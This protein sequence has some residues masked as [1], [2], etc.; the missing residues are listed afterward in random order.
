MG[1][2]LLDDETTH[3]IPNQYSSP[4]LSLQHSDWLLDLAYK[5]KTHT[6]SFFQVPQVLQKIFGKCW[7]SPC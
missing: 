3:G 2:Y 6:V 4:S 7:N 1:G 5:D